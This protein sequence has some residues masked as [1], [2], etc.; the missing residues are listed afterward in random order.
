MYLPLLIKK[1]SHISD[2]SCTV[3]VCF[4]WGGWKGMLEM[5]STALESL[6]EKMQPSET[7]SKRKCLHNNLCLSLYSPSLDFRWLSVVFL[8]VFTSVFF[9]WF[10]SRFCFFFSVDAS[11]YD[12][13]LITLH[14]CIFCYLSAL[15]NQ[16][17]SGQML[18]QLL[19][20]SILLVL[21]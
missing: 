11:V 12:I 21:L 14:P 4:E 5:S 6:W 19:L 15:L 1:A 17:Y 10:V 2:F 3:M 8:F 9:R 20:F 16:L 18:H 13:S 7:P